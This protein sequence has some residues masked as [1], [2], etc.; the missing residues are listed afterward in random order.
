VPV[1][2][3]HEGERR[4]HTVS[5]VRVGCENPDASEPIGG[6]VD[7]PIARANV[8]LRGQG[9]TPHEAGGLV[10]QDRRLVAT[11]G[12]DHTLRARGT[13]EVVQGEGAEQGRLAVLLRQDHDRLEHAGEVVGQD[14]PLERFELERPAELERELP[15]E[16]GEVGERGRA[17]TVDRT[18]R[19]AGS[20]AV[21]A[22][23]GHGRRR[24]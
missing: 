17:C 20:F 11:R 2:L 4:D 13:G 22:I 16:S 7:R 15:T 1:E 10:E 14:Q 18:P 12:A 5:G 19:A 23:G 24:F 6:E 3:V 9:R 21:E 8:E